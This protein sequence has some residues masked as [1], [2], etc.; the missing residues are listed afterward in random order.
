VKG[1]VAMSLN[2][3]I[4]CDND[5][6]WKISSDMKFFKEMTS[7]PVT[8]G[9]LLMGRKT[10]ESVGKPLP[11]R[12]TYVLTTDPEKRKMIDLRGYKYV[13][14]DDFFA[15]N[16]DHSKVWVCGGADVY[17]K[18]LPQC[19]V[20]Y[21]TIVLNEYEG[22]RFLEP[23]EEHFPIQQRILECPTHWVVKYMKS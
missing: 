15:L 2:R 18:F 8:G 5:I 21:A 9:F 6:P 19:D 12:H 23:F 20:V 7:D 13:N 16:S 22:D 14:E 11:N 4:G 3:V 17:K 10:F 1:I